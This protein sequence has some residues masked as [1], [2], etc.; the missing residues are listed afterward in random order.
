MV[1]NSCRI[2][3]LPF[4]NGQMH[5]HSKIMRGKGFG[6]GMGSVLLRKGGAGAA[7][8]YQDIDDYVATTGINPYSRAK[9]KGQGLGT[10]MD[11]MREKLQ[12][13]TIEQPSTTKPRVRKIQMSM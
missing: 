2:A 3:Q 9:S 12:K 13:L 1:F 6:C 7:S 11:R 4:S 10:G 5:A 8:S